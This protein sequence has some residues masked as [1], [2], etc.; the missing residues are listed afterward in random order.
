MRPL[1]SNDYKNGYLALLE[2]LTTVGDIHEIQWKKTFDRMCNS[3]MYYVV[4]IE[5][6]NTHK[7]VGNSTLFLEQKFI[8]NCVLRGR[9]EEVVVDKEYNGQGLGKALMTLL[10]ALAEHLGVYK[11]S[12]E[13][14]PHLVG[15][16]EQFGY[17]NDGGQYLVQRFPRSD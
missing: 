3:G 13:C 14:R 12:L 8:H 2:Q 11:L 4:V 17:K 6:I 5:E 16:Y 1:S 15:F 9:V 7:I 10:V